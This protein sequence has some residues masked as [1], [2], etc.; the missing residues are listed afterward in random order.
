[1]DTITKAEV[2]KLG[3]APDA[4]YVV[5]QPDGEIYFCTTATETAYDE[6]YWTSRGYTIK[7]VTEEQA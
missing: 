5:F 6:A 3:G 4:K 2:A 1:M 7:Q